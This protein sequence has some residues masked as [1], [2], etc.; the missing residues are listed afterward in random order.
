MSSVGMAEQLAG[1]GAARHHARRARARD[2]LTE[3]RRRPGWVTY[4]L[5][6]V[7]FV[8]SAYP[9]YFAFLLATSTAERIAQQPVPSPVPD[10]HLA[11]NLGRVA[12]SN[13]PIVAATANSV[14]VAVIVSASTVFFSTLAGY[15]FAKLRFRGRNPLLAFVVGTMAIPS[16][17][18]V[19]P[20]F[21]VMAKLG[22][23]GHL[24]SVIVPALVNAFGVFWMTQ[25]L[26]EALPYELIEAARMDGCSMFGTFWHVGLPA[27]R[28]AAS[29]LA[30][31]TF[32]ASC[33]NFFWPSIILGT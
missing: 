16:Q 8:I 9:L 20:L 1:R 11:E 26:A 4:A 14:I 6:T 28:P 17:L 21:I 24:P 19:I 13:V 18:G 5:L 27:A 25:Y 31:F 3:G 30:L 10:A 32:V 23:A 2:D 12:A 7:A 22:W 29:M 15:A 33:T